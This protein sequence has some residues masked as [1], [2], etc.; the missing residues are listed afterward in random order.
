MG[1]VLVRVLVK[2]WSL[3]TEGLETMQNHSR[4]ITGNE[5]KLHSHY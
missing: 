2:V 5:E 1:A 3:L 4:D